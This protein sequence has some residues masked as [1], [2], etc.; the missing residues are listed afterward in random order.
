VD[1]EQWKNALI[2][3]ADFYADHQNEDG[4]YYKVY[5]S[6]TGEPGFPDGE[7]IEDQTL[8]TPILIRFLARMYEFTGD[9]RYKTAALKAADYSYEVLYQDL[10]KYLGAATDNPNVIDK[11]SAAYAMFAF[12]AAYMLSGEEKY[13]AAAEHAATSAM[14]W[15]YCYDFA[16]PGA[17]GTE[18]VNP[19]KDGGRTSGFSVIAN[20]HFGADSWAANMYYEMFKLYAF[21]GKEFYLEAAKL[22]GFN[23]KQSSDY[24]GTMNWRYRALAPEATDISGFNF[25]SYAGG[26]WVTWISIANME[27]TGYM[28]DTFGSGDIREL[29]LEPE[30][31]R[32]QLDAY[33]IGGKLPE[34]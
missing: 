13:L 4:S 28:E 31:L 12:N 29:D 34:E 15:V 8:S 21:T 2:K 32:S 5:Y 11:E 6:K 24:D 16:C 26:H 20:G 30:T 1:K 23:T 7:A 14:S 27:S 22:L 25:E 10:G 17:P 3:V 18:D 9:T 33:G 19:F